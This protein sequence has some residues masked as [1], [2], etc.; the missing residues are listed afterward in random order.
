MLIFSSNL[1][2]ELSYVQ[3][4]S[5]MTMLRRVDSDLKYSGG[6]VRIWLV[7]G[8][9]TAIVEKLESGRWRLAGRYE[10]R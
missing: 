5:R 8:S 6:N 4:F 9:K 2:P 3:L 10:A 7:R 1:A